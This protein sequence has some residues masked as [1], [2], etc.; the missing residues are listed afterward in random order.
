MPAIFISYRRDDF[1]HVLDETEKRCSV[2]VGGAGMPPAEQ[3]PEA[4]APLARVP[5]MVLH[6]TSFQRDADQLIAALDQIVSPPPSA[7]FNW[8]LAA[9]VKYQLGRYLRRNLQ[10]RTGR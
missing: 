9:T 5:A 10:V 4:L 7:D 2:L 3:L 1:V 6:D 8:R